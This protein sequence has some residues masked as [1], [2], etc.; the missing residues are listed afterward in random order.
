MGRLKGAKVTKE[1][2]QLVIK[3]NKCVIDSRDMKHAA[4]KDNIKYYLNKGAEFYRQA[5]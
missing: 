1:Y 5:L 4:N 2:K 3:A